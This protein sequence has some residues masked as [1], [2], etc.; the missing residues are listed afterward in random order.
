[1]LRALALCLL[2]T[3]C[4]GVVRDPDP[5]P[6]GGVVVDDA[7]APVVGAIIVAA[8]GASATSDAQGRFVIPGLRDGEPL[9]ANAS[10]Y[11]AAGG[12]ASTRGV[13]L[14]LEPV[15]AIEGR[16]L[17]RGRGIAGA[18][19]EARPG[20]GGGAESAFTDAEGRFLVGGLRPGRQLLRI[21]LP[22]QA[23]GESGAFL[24]GPGSLQETATAGLVGLI[25]EIPVGGNLAVTGDPGASVTLSGE[26]ILERRYP[27]DETGSAR[28]EAVPPGRYV[29]TVHGPRGLESY[30]V[31]VQAPEPG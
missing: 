18:R 22:A 16:V 25:L 17:Y 3:A 21:E 8:G 19:V 29:V 2:L 1:M 27:L 28:F 15:R 14:R 9:E 12:Q 10:G 6:L 24:V 31:E 23:R 20:G 4:A 11:F 26:G 13:L 30:A 7:G 5:P